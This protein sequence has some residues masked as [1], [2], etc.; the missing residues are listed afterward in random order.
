MRVPDSRSTQVDV[1]M[2]SEHHG[3]VIAILPVPDGFHYGPRLVVGDVRCL[4]A[5]GKPDEWQAWLWPFPG[6]QMHVTQSCESITAPDAER[7]AGRLRKRA[8]RGAWW[9]KGDAP[10]A[11]N[12]E[13]SDAG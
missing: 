9:E 4:T 12:L 5:D 2:I 6:G 8:Q 3:L 10:A 13:G 7:L 11:Q 1:A